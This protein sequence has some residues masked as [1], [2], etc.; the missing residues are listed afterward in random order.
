MARSTPHDEQREEDREDIPQPTQAR[1][2]AMKVRTSGQAAT[3]APSVLHTPAVVR[4]GAVAQTADIGDTLTC[5]MGEWEGEPTGYAYQWLNGSNEI[6]TGASYVVAASDAPGS[7]RCVVTA[8]NGA[9]ATQAPPSN[10]VIVEATA[11]Q[12]Q[13]QEAAHGT[14]PRTAHT[15]RR[16]GSS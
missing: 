2:D 11:A 8:I 10:A 6:G 9:G 16:G 15:P 4:G 13:P 7:L 3:E 14:D 1:A 12:Q 5:T